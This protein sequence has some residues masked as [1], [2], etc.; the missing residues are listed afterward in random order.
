MEDKPTNKI[1]AP[2]PYVYVFITHQ[3]TQDSVHGQPTAVTEWSVTTELSIG[4]I[5]NY[6]IKMFSF[7]VHMFC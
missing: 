1:V 3:A 4:G 2:Y 5:Q 6:G 7:E